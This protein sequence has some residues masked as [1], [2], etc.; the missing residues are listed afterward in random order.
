MFQ[1][2]HGAFGNQFAFFVDTGVSPWLLHVDIV[3]M[4]EVALGVLL[5]AARKVEISST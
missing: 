5:R 4:S 1:S 2:G 3:A